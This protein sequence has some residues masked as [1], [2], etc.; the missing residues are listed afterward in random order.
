MIGLE[1]ANSY[2]VR[3]AV[4][5][6]AKMLHNVSN[7]CLG[8]AAT[9]RLDLRPT[10]G[11]G[12]SVHRS[13][14]CKFRR[15]WRHYARPALACTREKRNAPPVGDL[16][17]DA[18]WLGFCNLS[19]HVM[20]RDAP[21]LLYSKIHAE[22]VIYHLLQIRCVDCGAEHTAKPSKRTLGRRQVCPL[23]FRSTVVGGCICSE[24][25]LPP[26][27]VQHGTVA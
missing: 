3:R 15:N 13:G 5:W 2:F 18:L 11:V 8:K 12:R 22:T 14:I 1:P 6:P 27:L 16:Q 26:L 10:A 24:G 9:Q 23:P 4:L 21:G 20:F 7:G 17:L 25:L 19:I